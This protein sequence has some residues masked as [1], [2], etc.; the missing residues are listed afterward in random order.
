MT[1]MKP[2]IPYRWL[3]AVLALLTLLLYLMAGCTSSRKPNGTAPAPAVARNA[4]AGAEACAPCHIEES[5]GFS[6]TNHARTF[7]PM[8]SAALGAQAPPAGPLPDTNCVLDTTNDRYVVNVA[9]TGEKK[10]L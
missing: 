2:S 9:S 6:Q 8:T 10:T 1:R 5:R 7:R 4:Y 3:C